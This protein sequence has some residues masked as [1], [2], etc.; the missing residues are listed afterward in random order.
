MT[1][2]SRFTAAERLESL[3]VAM[4]GGVVAGLVTASLELLL[5][6]LNFAASL[7][8]LHFWLQ[9][10]IGG[11]SGALFALTYRYA[12]RQDQN[13][14]LKT[15]VVLAFTLVRGLAQGE[16]DKNLVPLLLT[17]GE[18]LLLFGLTALIINFGMQRSYLKPFM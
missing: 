10:A 4:V 18:S 9:T 3:K 11:L 14:Q 16:L 8:T 15:G 12:I 1:I 2:D 17:C 13:P 6:P 5:D 7:A